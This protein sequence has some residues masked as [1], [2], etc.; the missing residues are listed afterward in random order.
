MP[1]CKQRM[2]KCKQR[3]PECQQIKTLPNW[4]VLYYYDEI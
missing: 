3:M 4:T 1:K 2:P